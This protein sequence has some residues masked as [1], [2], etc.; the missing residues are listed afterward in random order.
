[1]W[2]ALWWKEVR[3]CGLYAGL[4]LLAQVHLIGAGI[5]LPLIPFLSSGRGNE[6]PFLS[7][8]NF[9]RQMYF[10]AIAVIAAVVLGLQQ[11]L[12][13]SWR[14]T[15][16]FLLHRPMPRDRIFLAKLSAGAALLLL[17]TAV[18]LGIYCLWAATPGTHASPFY[19]SMTEPSWRSALIAVVCYLGAFLAG[20][21]PAHWLGSRTWPAI[22][23]IVLALLLKLPHQ[24]IPLAYLVLFGL[25]A[26]LMISILDLARQ[27]EFP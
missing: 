22:A 16:L 10:T 24:W 11:T 5:G 6:I 15:T 12:W 7:N 9:D 19:W 13:E 18:P 3:E 27:R 1:M 20:L 4:A 2:T 21:R 25:M 23:A 26:A 14:Q 17:V 8:Y